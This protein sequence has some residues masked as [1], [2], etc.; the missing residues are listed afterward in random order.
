M[1]QFKLK[2]KSKGFNLLK[3]LLLTNKIIFAV[4]DILKFVCL[5][6]KA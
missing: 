2:L 6:H 3:F 1:E 5:Q 4:K